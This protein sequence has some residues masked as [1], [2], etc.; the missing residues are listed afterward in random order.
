MVTTWTK[1]FPGLGTGAQY[2][3]NLIGSMSGGRL[4]IKLYAAG[5]LVPAFETFDAVREGTA[6]G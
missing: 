3:A 5:K 2:L 4:K 6:E 1:T